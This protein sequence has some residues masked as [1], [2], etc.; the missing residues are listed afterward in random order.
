MQDL[1]QLSSSSHRGAEIAFR[2]QTLLGTRVEEEDMT[3]DAVHEWAGQEMAILQ[4]EQPG[5]SES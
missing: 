4:I 2:T 1:Y 3:R 5:Q